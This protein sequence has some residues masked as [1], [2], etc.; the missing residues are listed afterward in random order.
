MFESRQVRN[1]KKEA[2]KKPS[3]GIATKEQ[4]AHSESKYLRETLK[5]QCGIATKEQ[6]AHSESKYLRET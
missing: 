1:E 6:K 4:K 3:R 2:I 5:S